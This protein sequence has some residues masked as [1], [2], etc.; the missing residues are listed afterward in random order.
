MAVE[1]CRS[2]TNCFNSV[3]LRN[4]SRNHPD[5]HKLHH[6]IV[7]GVTRPRNV[8]VPRFGR[9]SKNERIFYPADVCRGDC[10][11]EFALSMSQI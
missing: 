10:G 5:R 11:P 6:M 9:C 7:F 4:D 1:P 8:D 3:S 2:G